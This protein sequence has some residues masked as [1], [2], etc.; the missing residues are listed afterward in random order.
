MTKKN[1]GTR[2]YLDEYTK[3]AISRETDPEI[4]KILINLRTRMN[5]CTDLRTNNG[6]KMVY[7]SLTKLDDQKNNP[8]CNACDSAAMLLDDISTKWFS[9]LKKM[10]ENKILF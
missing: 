10:R 4:K 9:N 5:C 3:K 1:Q 7:Q 6:K 8:K 2:S